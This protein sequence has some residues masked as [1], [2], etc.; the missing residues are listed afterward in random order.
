MVK[1][2]EHIL[3]QADTTFAEIDEFGEYSSE[4]VDLSLI[5]ASLARTPLQRLE[6]ND[7]NRWIF[8]VTQSGTNVS[9]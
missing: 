6:I 3:E 9:R 8:E 1:H 2:V 4:G 7:E 5:R